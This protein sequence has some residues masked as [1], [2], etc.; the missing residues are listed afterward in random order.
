[1]NVYVGNLAYST[2]ESDLR[3]LFEQHGEVSSAN[4]IVDRSTGQ[5]KGFGFIEMPQKEQADAAIAAL[6]GS[7][8]N[9]RSITVNEAR[10]R[11]ERPQRRNW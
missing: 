3:A 4:L 7:D 11:Q 9:G 6:N 5:S 8:L 1:M 2:T 10:P